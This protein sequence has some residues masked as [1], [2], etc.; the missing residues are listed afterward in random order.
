MLI[1]IQREKYYSISAPEVWA[2]SLQTRGVDVRWVD[3][4]ADDFIGQ[5]KGCDGLIFDM[6]I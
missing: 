6:D 4:T 3:L 2:E 1:A 5:L